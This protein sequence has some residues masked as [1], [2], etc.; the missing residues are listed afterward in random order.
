VKIRRCVRKWQPMATLLDFWQGCDFQENDKVR[1]HL[2]WV[3]LLEYP[4]T[5]LRGV[6]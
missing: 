6:K 1:L 3:S 2:I 4:V 5:K